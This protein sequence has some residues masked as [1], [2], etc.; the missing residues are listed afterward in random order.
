LLSS[1][2]FFLRRSFESREIDYLLATPLTRT[3]LLASF[4]AAFMLLACY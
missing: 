2:S 1:I 4:A 3:K